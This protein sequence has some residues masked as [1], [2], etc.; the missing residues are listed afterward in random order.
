MLRRPRRVQIFFFKRTQR[1]FL[2]FLLVKLRY[3]VGVMLAGDFAEF[4]DVNHEQQE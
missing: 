2:K 1:T 3:L 4:L